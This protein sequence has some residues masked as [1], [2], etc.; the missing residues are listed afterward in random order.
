[1]SVLDAWETGRTC[2]FAPCEDVAQCVF[3]SGCVNHRFVRSQGPQEQ[4]KKSAPALNGTKPRASRDPR[5]IKRK[6][7]ALPPLL[8][9]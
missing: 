3:E 9:R 7:K 6:R 8:L 4:L 2:A 1:M 5:F